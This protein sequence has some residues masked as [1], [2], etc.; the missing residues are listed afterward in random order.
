MLNVSLK[1]SLLP[2][3]LLC[4]CLVGISTAVAGNNVSPGN[5]GQE[6]KTFGETVEAQ[7]QAARFLDQQLKSLSMANALNAVISY[8]PESTP[9]LVSYA[10]ET[11]PEKHKEIVIGAIRA[12]PA[13]IDEVIKRTAASGLIS[14]PEIIRL[15]VGADPSFAMDATAAACELEP[16]QFRQILQTAL[17]LEPDS[18]DLIAQ[19]VAGRLPNRTLEVL[20]TVLSEVPYLGNYVV[21][22]LLAIFPQQPQSAALIL[23]ALEEL[24]QQP[25]AISRLLELAKTRNLSEASA[26][27]AIERGGLSESD[28]TSA[29]AGVYK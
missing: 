26:V 23:V 1:S 7:P 19:Q 24:A 8:Y 28:A 21:D 2:T 12:E 11:Y 3:K 4:W 20:T 5:Y 18:A 14:V 22:A 25:D 13:F 27:S 17:A 10:L 15:A 16:S 29:V 9:E 6:A